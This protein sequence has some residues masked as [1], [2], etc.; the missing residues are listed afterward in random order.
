MKVRLM[1]HVIDDT[2]AFQCYDP[3][4]I[5]RLENESCQPL[6]LFDT[7]GGKSAVG[8]FSNTKR[9]RLNNLWEVC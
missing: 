9:E 5:V 3:G 6:L 7:R 4:K 8:K 1:V 2:K